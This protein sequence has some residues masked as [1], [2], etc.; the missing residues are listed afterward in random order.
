MEPAM[1]IERPHAVDLTPDEVAHL[2]QLRQL[3]QLALADGRLSKA[4]MQSIQALMQADQRVT[5][6]ELTTVRETIRQVLGDAAL[7]YDWQ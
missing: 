1:K 4:E 5:V 3:I 2:D 6:A 7:E